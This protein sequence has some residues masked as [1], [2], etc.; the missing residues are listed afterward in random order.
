M[1]RQQRPAATGVSYHVTGHGNNGN[2]IFQDDYDR[3]AY[4]ALLSKAVRE[5]EIRLFAY[6]FMTTHVHLVVQTLQK[7]ISRVVHRLHGTYAQAYN[8][9]YGYHGHLFE[10]R[11]FSKVIEDDSYLLS[12][13]RYVHRNP[14]D[15]GLVSHPAEYVWSSYM[16][17]ARADRDQALVDVR[18][19]LG[20]FGLDPER[21]REAYTRFVL[22]DD[23]VPGT[24][25]VAAP[26]TVEMHS[27]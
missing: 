4:L 21:S 13:T 18:P 11:F 6:I 10:R 20:V 15:A 27:L 12:S 2:V 5:L 9:R 17:Y 8:R 3:Y 22:D 1:P 24:V 16:Y 7:S 14:L 23:A 19:V 25:E 26:A